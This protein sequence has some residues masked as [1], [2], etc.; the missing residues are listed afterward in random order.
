MYRITEAVLRNFDIKKMKKVCN[1]PGCKKKPEKEVYIYEYQIKKSIGITTLYLC[2]EHLHS[3]KDLAEEIKR[4]S[5][6]MIVQKKERDIGKVAQ[7][8]RAHG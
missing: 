8:G 1:Y 4:I 3:A 5:P 6:K 7:P 2:K